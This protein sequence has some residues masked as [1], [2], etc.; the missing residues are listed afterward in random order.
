MA[1]IHEKIV[2]IMKNVGSIGKNKRNQ[3]Q[4]F[5]FRGIDDVYNTL[6]PLLSEHGVFTLPKVLESERQE[7][8]TAKG[9]VL[10]FQRLRV[11]YTFIAED[12]SSVDCIVEGE[13]MDSGDKATNKAMS[14]AHKYAMFQVFCIPTEEL[15]DP[16]YESHSL[17][18]NQQPRQPQQQQAV[19]P[20]TDAQRKA[21]Q[22]FY[23]N[24][25]ERY[26]DRQAR[27][28]SLSKW[29]QRPINSMNDMTIDEASGLLDAIN[30]EEQ[31]NG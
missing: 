18:P 9:G 7:R 6:H 12:G 27:L 25:Q 19:R 23:S 30:Q 21:L 2:A 5:N 3:Q 28:D 8:A 20:I 4:G 11:E 1:L 16:D 29:C 24:N 14:V 26:P 31:Q 17:A 22:A 10:A 13:G 15:V